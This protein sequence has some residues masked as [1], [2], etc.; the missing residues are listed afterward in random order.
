M[1]IFGP[2]GCGKTHLG[3]VWTAKATRPV[4]WADIDK[5]NPETFIDND[6]VVFDDFD[7]NI[8]D[9]QGLFHLINHFKSEGK[10]FLILS[11][12]PPGNWEFD[13]KDLQSRLSLLPAVRM[14]HVDDALLEAIFIKL[15]SDRQLQIDPAVVSYVLKHVDRS[16]DKLNMLVERLDQ[17]GL[18][19]GRNITLPFTKQV[20]EGFFV[21]IGQ[22]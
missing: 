3:H 8:L 17:E 18:K 6:M 2:K 15:I 12:T 21:E 13:L 22:N 19:Q 5:I 1:I 14:D 4:C 9:Q 7:P 10:F 11:E 20:I 16:V